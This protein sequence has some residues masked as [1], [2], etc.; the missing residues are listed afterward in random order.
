M[1]SPPPVHRQRYCVSPAA[2]SSSSSCPASA[3]SPPRGASWS[4][5]IKKSRS[6]LP[7][8]ASSK[9]V[10]PMTASATTLCLTSRSPS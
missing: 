9:D 1:G 4:H 3:A 8:M 6:P 7:A 10:R 5:T 2:F